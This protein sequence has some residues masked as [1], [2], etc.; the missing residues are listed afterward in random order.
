MARRLGEQDGEQVFGGVYQKEGAAQ[1]APAVGACRTGAGCQAGGLAH[2]HAQAKAVACGQDVARCGDTAQVVGGH[3]TDGGAAGQANGVAVRALYGALAQHQLQKA[4]V[5]AGGGHQ[6]AASGF[7]RGRGRDIDQRHLGPGLRVARERLGQVG[8]AVGQYRKPRV[9]HAQGFQ[10]T[11]FQEGAQALAFDHLQYRTQHIGGAAVFPAAARLVHQRQ[12]AERGHQ[13]GIAVAPRA[14]AGR[15]V[16][17]GHRAGLP[18]IAQ[19]GGVAQQVVHRGF[20]LHG[21]G[22]A[23]GF[24]VHPLACKRRQVVRDRV[25]QQ[26]AAFFHEHQRRQ[27]GDGFGHGIDAEHGVGRHGGRACPGP[28]G[29][30]GFVQHRAPLVVHQGHCAGQQTLVDVGL[31]CGAQVGKGVGVHGA[32]SPGGWVSALRISARVGVGGSPGQQAG[33]LL[34]GAMGS[35]WDR[36]YRSC[37]ETRV[38]ARGL[39]P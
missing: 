7:K 32:V 38:D 27:R 26:Q 1:S 10:N 2:G 34:Q 25:R 35:M 33:P 5:V 37:S 39:P 30:H 28:L 29:A 6:P 22:G 24:V 11:A 15:P 14:D 8:Q 9:V 20:A 19:P 3:E 4:C 23:G 18:R 17:V 21:G 13:L 12:R 31:E 16:L 36:A